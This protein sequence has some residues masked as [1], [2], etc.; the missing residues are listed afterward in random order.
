MKTANADAVSSASGRAAAPPSVLVEGAKKFYYMG[1][2]T[3]RAVDGIDL[4]IEKGE[5]VSIMGPSGSGK[6][7]LFNIVGGLTK[8]T[9]G[10]VYIDRTDISKLD[11]SELAWL[12]CRKI[13]YV[14]QTFN[15]VPIMSAL[16]NVML[17]LIF[18][19]V[20]RTEREDRA[21]EM[22]KLVGLGERVHHKPTELSGGQQQRVAIARAF[23]NNP[24]IVLADE[25]TGNLDLKTGLHI[26]DM[27][28]EMNKSRG[29]TMLCNTHDQ[30]IIKASDRIVWVSD[31]RVEKIER[32]A[33]AQAAFQDE[34]GPKA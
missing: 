25:P 23:V 3:V 31:G 4:R 17:P 34:G 26:I 13:G 20:D 1:G 30:K 9:E 6:T 22:L 24:A 2:E 14:F 16:Q 18:G 11:A 28:I 10:T 5:Y 32:P 27:M 19:G 12:R 29:V 21:H 15:L 7:T 33:E 8:P